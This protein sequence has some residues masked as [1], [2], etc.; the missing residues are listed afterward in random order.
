MDQRAQE[1]YNTV[2]DR[3]LQAQRRNSERQAS[4]RSALG[5][6]GRKLAVGD[7]AYLLMKIDG[8][9]TTVKGPFLVCELSEWH[10][11][12]RTSGAVQG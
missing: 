8:F 9:K 11:E 10:A 3:I 5:K 4:R 2:H 1:L 6:G 12:L 7:L